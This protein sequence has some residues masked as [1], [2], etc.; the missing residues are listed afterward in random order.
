M[1]QH[2]TT[3]DIM[4]REQSVF[5]RYKIFIFMFMYLYFYMFSVLYIL[6]LS[7]QLALFVYPDWGFS[8]LFPQL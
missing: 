3:S 6:F 1:Q 7:C 4:N 8:V 2:Q 5:I